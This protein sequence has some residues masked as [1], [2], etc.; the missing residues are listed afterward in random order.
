MLSPPTETSRSKDQQEREQTSERSKE[1]RPTKPVRK[2]HRA[3]PST[4]PDSKPGKYSFFLST[5]TPSADLFLASDKRKAKHVEHS[6]RN[7]AWVKS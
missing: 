2:V 6:G 7:E 3:S 5:P 4:E 1:R